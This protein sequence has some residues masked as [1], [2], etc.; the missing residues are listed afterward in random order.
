MGILL[1]N[2]WLTQPVYAKVLESF[3]HD[4]LKLS[5][6]LSLCGNL[7]R[8][9]NLSLLQESSVS[10]GLS[11]WMCSMCWKWDMYMCVSICTCLVA[12]LQAPP[13]DTAGYGRSPLWCHFSFLS[14]YSQHSAA[15]SWEPWELKAGSLAPSGGRK[16]QRE[17]ERENTK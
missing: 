7:R 14:G 13:G 1:S 10:I 5:L 3:L 4:Q 16:R 9:F 17:T 6:P 11:Q 15:S 2:M 12:L 8:H